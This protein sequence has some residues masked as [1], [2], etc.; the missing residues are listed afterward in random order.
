MDHSSR[1]EFLKAVGLTGLA[2]GGCSRAQAPETP[3]SAAPDPA[4]GRQTARVVIARLPGYDRGADL[5]SERLR[6]ILERALVALTGAADAQEAWRRYFV[7]QDIVALKVNALAGP[8]LSTHPE[9]CQAAVAGLVAAG[10]DESRIIVYDRLTEELEVLGFRPNH[11][12][13]GLKVMGSDVTGYDLEPT[14]V[15]AVGSCFSRIVS[16]VATAII[17]VPILKDHDLAGLS[18]ALKNHYG[19]INNPNKLHTDHCYPYVADLNC[20]RVLRSKQRLI[21]CDALEVCYEGGPAFQPASTVPYGAVLVA[22][23][24]VAADAVGLSILDELREEAGLPS[25][26]SL[27]RAPR[28]IKLAEEYGIGVADLRRIQIIEV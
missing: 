9:L 11:D 20:A 21:I 24:A 10:L 3:V 12:G 13:P 5:D 23:D 7:A 26:M 27:E 1:R 28:Y 4:A 17:N 16:E 8:Q 19:S 14:E 22:E 18:G 25:L 15:R 2:L 6:E